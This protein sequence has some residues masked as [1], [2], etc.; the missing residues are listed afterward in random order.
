MECFEL[1]LMEVLVINQK[2]RVVDAAIAANEAAT[3]I[4]EP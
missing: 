3:P 4:I 1:I 2:R